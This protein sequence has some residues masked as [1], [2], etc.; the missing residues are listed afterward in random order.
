M[1]QMDMLHLHM[2]IIIGFWVAVSKIFGIFIP[3]NNG[4]MIQIWWPFDDHIF[5]F[6]WLN[7]Q[8]TKPRFVATTTRYGTNPE[9]ACGLD[10]G[11]LVRGTGCL[12]LSIGSVSPRYPSF[13]IPSNP[14]ADFWFW[15]ISIHPTVT[16]A[17]P[18]IVT[19]NSQLRLSCSCFGRSDAKR[20][21]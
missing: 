6:G 2:H 11:A 8:A 19:S 14:S 7:H 3:Q 18:T 1:L 4:E 5:Q 9:T 21:L 15:Y 20:M 10:S 17:P 12:A 13:Q 16:S